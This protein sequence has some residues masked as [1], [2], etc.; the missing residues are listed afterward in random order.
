MRAETAL[1]FVAVQH[2]S[3]GGAHFFAISREA[4]RLAPEGGSSSGQEIIPARGISLARSRSR[5]LRQRRHR[6]CRGDLHGARRTAD[7][8][9]PPRAGG[10]AGKPCPT[11]GVRA[12]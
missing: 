12:D 9:P 2:I 1:I 7:A 5:T 6:A 11:R 10:A 8:D 3:R 4:V